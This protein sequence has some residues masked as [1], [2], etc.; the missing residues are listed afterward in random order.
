MSFKHITVRRQK[1]KF[2]TIWWINVVLEI[3]IQCDA[4]IDLELYM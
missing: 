1:A 3:L 4:N 2:K